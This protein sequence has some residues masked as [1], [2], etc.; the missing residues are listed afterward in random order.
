MPAASNK[1]GSLKILDYSQI[2]RDCPAYCP[3]WAQ[4]PFRKKTSVALKRIYSM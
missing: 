4:K 1:T 3:S 2:L